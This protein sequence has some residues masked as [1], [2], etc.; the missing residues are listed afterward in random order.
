MKKTAGDEF[1]ETGVM[2]D[3]MRCETCCWYDEHEC[4]FNPPVIF[5]ERGGSGWPFTKKMAYC[6]KYAKFQGAA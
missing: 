4:H 3:G 1:A 5:G 6:S 2:P